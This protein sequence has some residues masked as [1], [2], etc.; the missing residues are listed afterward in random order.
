MAFVYQPAV[1]KEIANSMGLAD[2]NLQ[3][4]LDSTI[5]GSGVSQLIS[6]RNRIAA[7]IGDTTISST[8]FDASTTLGQVFRSR[9]VGISTSLN[10]VYSSIITGVNTYFSSVTT[11]TMR[12]YYDSKSTTTSLDFVSAG[13]SYTTGLASFR[14]LYSRIQSEELIY[15]LYSVATT[16]VT[17]SI[18]PTAYGYSTS[19]TNSSLELRL[20]GN[21]G[22]ATTFTVSGDTTTGSPLSL[23][24]TVGAGTSVAN[25]GTTQKFYNV[26]VLGV[27]AAIGTTT[28]EI[29]T[30]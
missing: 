1:F 3:D 25:V 16:G 12:N 29:W 9:E 15:K 14:K 28:V 13:T 7:S 27:P 11:K 4:Q 6:S 24:V 23:S 17:A 26:S 2:K 30:R 20:A 21:V 22:T 19:F 18:V 10:T 8:D 5:V